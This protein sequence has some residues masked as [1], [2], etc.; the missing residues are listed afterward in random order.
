M[1]FG[2]LLRAYFK[3]S[4]AVACSFGVAFCLI[5]NLVMSERV[6]VTTLTIHQSLC[7]ANVV[8][9]GLYVEPVTFAV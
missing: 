4:W 7:A 8:H 1:C 3:R 5:F 2:C 9:K 6:T